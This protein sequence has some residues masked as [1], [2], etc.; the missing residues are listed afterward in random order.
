[1]LL[2][3]MSHLSWT[4]ICFTVSYLDLS[5]IS[6]SEVCFS[7]KVLLLTH[8]YALENEGAWQWQHNPGKWKIF[9]K[10]FVNMR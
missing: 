3:K 5:A 6:G 2:E 9:V 10:V 8:R 7:F 1:M 4:E